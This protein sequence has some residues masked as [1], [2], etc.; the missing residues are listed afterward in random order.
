MRDIDQD[1][2]HDESRAAMP[3]IFCVCARQGAWCE[4][5]IH[6]AVVVEW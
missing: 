6:S 5:T 4:S 2:S 1:T 3:G